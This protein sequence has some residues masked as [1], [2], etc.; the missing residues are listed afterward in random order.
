MAKKKEGYRTKSVD[1][2]FLIYSKFNFK[3]WYI[4]LRIRVLVG[5][6]YEAS[7]LSYL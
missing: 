1:K 3:M 5:R 7:K 2:K 4:F 6:Y